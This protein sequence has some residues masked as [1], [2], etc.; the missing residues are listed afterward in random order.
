MKQ[1]ISFLFFLIVAS[2]TEARTVSPLKV[3][4]L[5][6]GGEI[7]TVTVMVH[8][9][10]HLLGEP[11]V[12]E[13]YP[14]CGAKN[15]TWRKIEVRDVKSACVIYPNTIALSPDKKKITMKIQEVDYSY[16]TMFALKYPQ[17][18]TKTRCLPEIATYTFDL[19]GICKKD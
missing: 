8:K 3:K 2:M 11:Y 19:E 4:P 5:K 14:T 10:G 15:K 12:A 6:V 1:F 18:E 17:R 7:G 16:Q 9:E 13:L